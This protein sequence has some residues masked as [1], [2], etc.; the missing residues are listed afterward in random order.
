MSRLG[1]C[2]SSL[3][4][5]ITIGLLF[6]TSHVAVADDNEW[7]FEAEAFLWAA[8]I[9]GT[10]AGGGA[11]F[12]IPFHDIVKH[13]DMVAMG[14]IAAR[15]DKLTFFTDIVHL[16]ISTDEKGSYSMPI[17]PG[18][19][20][21]VG[22]KLDVSLKSWIVQPTAAYTIFKNAESNIDLLAGVRY[23]WV[24]LDY[25]LKTTGQFLG[26]VKHTDSD[27]NWD[28]I[29]GVKGN[30]ELSDKWSIF[31]YADGGTGDSD[32][33]VQGLAALNYKFDNFTGRFGYRY[34]KWEF[35]GHSLL[36]NLTI[37]GP[38]LGA[39]FKF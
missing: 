26:K 15:K 28:G 20:I 18:N 31:A 5:L 32:Y 25:K 8:D 29:V 19:G 36:E 27:Q 12:E 10:D 14:R 21:E 37:K 33:T 38:Y 3:K 13:L 22:K 30:M 11:N 4:G 24:E 34:L 39:L 35:E 16:D 23:I 7:Q 17:G 1:T 6:A 9:I 2:I